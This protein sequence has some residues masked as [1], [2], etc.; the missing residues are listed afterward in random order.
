M[1]GG[2]L[3]SQ[4]KTETEMFC[5][6]CEQTSQGKGCSIYGV[7]GKSPEVARLQDLLVY[8]LKGFSQV[9]LEARKVGIKDEKTDLFIA[10]SMFATL[11]NVNFD[12]DSIIRYLNWAVEARESL[13]KKIAGTGGKTDFG[14]AANLSLEKSKEGM[15]KQAKQF[16]I[17]A[18]SADNPRL[19]RDALALNLRN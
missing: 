16:G 19:E 14:P 9:V 7:C 12:P 10:E 3:M 2:K 4:T 11:T 6:Q 17:Q 1:L 18:D 8:T 15:V 13:K 5:W